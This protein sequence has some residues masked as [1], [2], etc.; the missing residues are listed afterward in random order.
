[1]TL[2]CPYTGFSPL[3]PPKAMPQDI[4]NYCHWD[5]NL[6][7][8]PQWPD[9]PFLQ[10]KSFLESRN[11][12]FVDS[13]GNSHQDCFQGDI[14]NTNTILVIHS[15]VGVY[16]L[17]FSLL[18]QNTWQKSLKKGRVGFGLQ[19][20]A[21]STMLEK[22]AGGNLRQ[23]GISSVARELRAVNAGA[24]PTVRTLSNSHCK[25]AHLQMV[26]IPPWILGKSTLREVIFPGCP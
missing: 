1:M 23:L 21:Q 4:R 13:L 16:R 26:L 5:H 19:F 20:G 9:C 17:F 11:L 12:D 6:F 7:Q 2:T 24:Q 25:L 15:E 8:G 14:G 18:S 22:S 10:K 3:L